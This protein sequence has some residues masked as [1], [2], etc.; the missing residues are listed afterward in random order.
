[1]IT[2]TPILPFESIAL[3]RFGALAERWAA[4]RAASRERSRIERELNSFS[5]AELHELGLFRSDIPA[6]ANGTYRR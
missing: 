2:T 5:D 3:P 6:V 4:F 1:M